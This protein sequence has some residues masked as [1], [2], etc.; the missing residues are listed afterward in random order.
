MTESQRRSHCDR[1]LARKKLFNLLLASCALLSGQVVG[2]AAP[3]SS[4]V[5][6]EIFG[7]EFLSE[8]VLDVRQQVA[9]LP[10]HEAFALLSDWVLPGALHLSFRSG[11]EFTPVGV[12]GTGFS[13]VDGS[14]W[15]LVSPVVDLLDVA[16]RTGRLQELRDRVALIPTTQGDFQ[17][18]SKTALLVLLSLELNDLPAARKYFDVFYEAVKNSDPVEM[19]EQ[20][21][22]TLV[23]DRCVRKFP[24]FADV[25][26][27]LNLL[28]KQRVLKSRPKGAGV[29]FSYW[30][31]LT[32]RYQ[33]RQTLERTARLSESVHSDEPVTDLISVTRER[34]KSRGQGVP[35]STWSWNGSS[36]QHIVGHDEDYLLFRSPLRGNFQ[37]EA[38]LQAPGNVHV[39]TAGTLFGP[40]NKFELVTGDFRSGPVIQKVDPPFTK[41]NP[42]I[43]YRA[44]VHDGVVKTWLHGRLVDEKYVSPD[45]DPWV[46]IRSWGRSSGVFR[47]LRITG[48]PKIPAS[49]EI[50]SPACANGWYAYHEDSVGDV[51][52][53]ARWTLAGDATDEAG[54]QISGWRRT[55]T[56]GSYEESLLRYFRPLIEDGSVEYEFFYKPGELHVHPALGRL[57]IMLEPEGV[58]LHRITD[59][60]Y[61]RTSLSPDNLFEAKEQEI[62]V[63][64]LPLKADEWN[65]L[66]LSIVDWSLVVALNDES[67][68]A[69]DLEATN[70]RHFGLFHFS[71]R[72]GVRVRRV[73]MRGDWSRELPQ[74]A[75]QQL[76]DGQPQKLDD[77][78]K[79]FCPA[80][81]H[82]FGQEGLSEEFFS[83]GGSSRGQFQ[84]GANGLTHIQRGEGKY[85]QSQLNVAFR[86][87]RD[88]DVT[89]AFADLVLPSL[90]NSSCELTLSCEGGYQVSIRRRWQM[91]DPHRLAVTWAFPAK[92]GTEAANAGAVSRSYEN[93]PTEI[94]GGRFRIAR[95]GDTVHV[96]VA[97]YDS[98]EF[99]VLTSRT[100][101]TIGERPAEVLC[102]SSRTSL[103]RHRSPGKAF[104]SRLMSCF[105]CRIW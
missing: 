104:D 2:I 43:R 24:D 10:D 75:S 100:I 72:T 89:A 21:P 74:V 15:T 63:R 20:W 6:V 31:S 71:D 101:E 61:D 55:S 99:R 5:A 11:G 1:L 46:G 36:C 45:F 39:L 58:R 62:A 87:H 23:A 4:D 13:E 67:I 22:E 56:A 3:W 8:N 57:A 80:F 12:T 47:D 29:W 76:A 97:E 26:D 34:G 14:G 19:Y 42:W 91:P 33:Y 38:D 98:D 93:F 103:R 52:S 44:T 59:G 81:N 86:M 53:S 54:I 17:S 40:R 41:D 95:R 82:D 18:R 68:L 73:V 102:V 9:L 7:E 16:A 83:T 35:L 32:R 30:A 25:G 96:L 94:S 88:L 70:S 84:S 105:C 49:V 85:T 51:G 50:S 60:K 77:D 27:L 37:V 66:R 78:L 92:P 28:M 69:L 65:R 90:D 79:K 48:S 64:P